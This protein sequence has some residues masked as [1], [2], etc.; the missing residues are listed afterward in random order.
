MRLA[1]SESETIDKLE[2]FILRTIKNGQRINVVHYSFLPERPQRS[3]TPTRERAAESSGGAR[4]PVTEPRPL[5]QPT[6]SQLQPIQRPLGL[7]ESG[8]GEAGMPRPRDLP[9][10]DV[11]PDAQSGI[12]QPGVAVG[13]QVVADPQTLLG[14]GTAQPAREQGTPLPSANP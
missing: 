4:P 6:E 10:P 8:G 1:G 11:T 9:E 12:G 7:P 3:S 2:K 5:S 13:A 14:V